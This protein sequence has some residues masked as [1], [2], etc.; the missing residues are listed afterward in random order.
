MEN[1]CPPH[2]PDSRSIVKT[3][4]HTISFIWLPHWNQFHYWQTMWFGNIQ[5]S[6][7]LAAV[8]GD[9]P[10]WSPSDPWFLCDKG[11]IW[12]TSSELWR[13][14]CQTPRHASKLGE[15]EIMC[16]VEW[17]VDRYN[18]TQKKKGSSQKTSFLLDRYSKDFGY[19]TPW[20]IYSG[21]HIIS[22]FCF[23]CHQQS[24]SW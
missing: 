7:A 10:V 5:A 19:K 1:Y 3:I 11:T 12:S 22:Q 2:L 14:H 8:A 23:L 15:T 20:V 6:F 18:V 17:L 13:S 4:K 24:P 16:N 21:I 9:G